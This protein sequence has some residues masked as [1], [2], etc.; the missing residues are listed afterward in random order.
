MASAF[1]ALIMKSQE[2]KAEKI[3]SKMNSKRTESM[4]YVWQAIVN[5]KKI[6]DIRKYVSCRFMLFS[7]SQNLRGR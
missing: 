5:S 4:E 6:A 3:P 1:F 2:R 7:N